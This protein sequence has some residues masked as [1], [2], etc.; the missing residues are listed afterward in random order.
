ME[1]LERLE[2]TL[3]GLIERFTDGVFRTPVQPVEIGKRLIR[4]MDSHRTVAPSSTFVPNLFVIVVGADTFAK[5]SMLCPPL[6]SEFETLLKQHVA[7]QGYKTVGPIAVR[8]QEDESLKAHEVKITPVSM[9]T[10]P[11]MD[12]VLDAELAKQ[13]TVLDPHPGGDQAKTVIAG[14][15]RADAPTEKMEEAAGTGDTTTELLTLA[16][17]IEVVEGN[18]AGQTIRLRN[19]LRIG[20]GTKNDVPLSDNAVS[21]DHLEFVLEGDAWVVRDLG[22]ANKTKVN[23][24]VVESAPLTPGDEILIGR[25]KLVVRGA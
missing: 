15:G 11:P 20:R 2:K 18:E 16:P 23:D 3:E 6:L 25:T 4:E 12:A 21:R 8:L 22:S 19:G 5:F 1:L 24:V 7:D 10:P 17:S 9:K 14:T 13:G